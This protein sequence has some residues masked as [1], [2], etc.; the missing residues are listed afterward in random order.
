MRYFRSLFYIWGNWCALSCIG[1][2]P[3]TFQRWLWNSSFVASKTWTFPSGPLSL[4][5]ALTL[6]RT[7]NHDV[8][9]TLKFCGPWGNKDSRHH[10]HCLATDSQQ[11]ASVW[12]L[13][14][15]PVFGNRPGTLPGLEELLLGSPGSRGPAVRNKIKSRGRI[16]HPLAMC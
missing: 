3:C 2:M 10:S 6:G 13:C 15:P 4:W 5:G 11:D 14:L 1:H 16:A 9:E 12:L 7:S 8:R